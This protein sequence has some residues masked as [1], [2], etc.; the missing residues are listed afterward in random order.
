M[1]LFSLSHEFIKVRRCDLFFFIGKIEMLETNGVV[2]VH[3]MIKHNSNYRKK[4]FPKKCFV[5]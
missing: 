1:S 4:I 2:K 3:F 5:Q